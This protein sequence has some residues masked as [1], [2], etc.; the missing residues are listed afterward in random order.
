M[1]IQRFTTYIIKQQSLIHL[2]KHTKQ[3]NSSR[4]RKV[5]ARVHQV[6]SVYFFYMS[7]SNFT[8][9]EISRSQHIHRLNNVFELF[10]NTKIIIHILHLRPIVDRQK[11]SRIQCFCLDPTFWVVRLLIFLS[12]FFIMLLNSYSARIK[13]AVFEDLSHKSKMLVRSAVKLK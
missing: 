6:R 10:H 9:S 13:G 1:K 2:C 5:L 8:S 11:W 7:R 12:Q 3:G 4:E